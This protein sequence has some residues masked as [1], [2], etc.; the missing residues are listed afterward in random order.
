M[1]LELERVLNLS[2][3]HDCEELLRKADQLDPL[4]SLVGKYLDK[5]LALFP[6]DEW[7]KLYN[8]GTINVKIG[9]K[10]HAGFRLQELLE[11]TQTLEKLRSSSGYDRL[12]AGFRNPTQIKA[13]MF[14]IKVAEWCLSRKLS[15][16]LTL[17]PEFKI[18]GG[19]KYP[20]FIW[21]T[22][23]GDIVCECKSANNFQNKLSVRLHR[24]A[25]LLK[26]IYNSK[27]SWPD[28]LRLDVIFGKGTM[29]KIERDFKIVVNN[30]WDTIQTENGM[31]ELC[32]GN[33]SARLSPK[34]NPPEIPSESLIISNVKIGSKPVNVENAAHLSLTMSQVHYRL[35]AA[36]RLLRDAR[37]QLP[38]DK[39]GIIFLEGVGYKSVSDKVKELIVTPTYLNIPMVTLWSDRELNVA[40]YREN[41]PFDQRLLD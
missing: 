38:P 7:R 8:H 9:E 22:E 28:H 25:D 6:S 26:A 1:E 40:V 32:S 35:Q 11:V 39:V 16:G 4:G 12:I 15:Q 18:A 34:A 2:L 20:E 17:S 36:G 14:E 3:P 5:Y 21:H 41:Q 33:V 23:L 13:T 37:S 19:L 27:A 24:C 31:K 30:A 10:Q 29:N